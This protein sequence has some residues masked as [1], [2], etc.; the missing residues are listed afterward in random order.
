MLPAS[1]RKWLLV[2]VT[3]LVFVAGGIG[4]VRDADSRGWLGIVFF[5]LGAIVATAALLPGASS[6]TLDREGFEFTSLYRRSRRRWQDAT[7]FD[8]MQV[9]RA[10]TKLVVFDD[11]TLTGSWGAAA[12]IALSGRNA[13]LPD[14]YGF[15]ADEL[16]RLM[17]RWRE[18]AV[19]R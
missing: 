3:C 6:L 8:V 14:T 1:R 15:A 19:A 12:S 4:M 10:R 9:P 5:G 17:T 7:R 16:A 13:G 11:A 18:R 2:L